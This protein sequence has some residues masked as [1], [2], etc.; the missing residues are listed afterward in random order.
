M[1]RLGW[2]FYI[3]LYV[4]GAVI[5]EST[6]LVEIKRRHLQKLF[7]SSFGCDFYS[8]WGNGNTGNFFIFTYMRKKVIAHSLLRN[9]T[10]FWDG[11]GDDL[12]PAWVRF[13]TWLFS[14]FSEEQV[15]KGYGV[16]GAVVFLCKYN[17][18]GLMRKLMVGRV[19]WRG[20]RYAVEV[21]IICVEG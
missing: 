7:Y 11:N 21:S 14:L 20:K 13:W 5:V 8:S 1:L 16:Y 3:G 2:R 17:V 15:W 9:I 4:N 6:R 19:G 12:K 18:R 10:A